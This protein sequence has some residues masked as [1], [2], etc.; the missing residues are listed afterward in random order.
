MKINQIIDKIYEHH[1]FVPGL[2]PENGEQT[3]HSGTARF[4]S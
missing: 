4:K 3:T 1:L 2:P